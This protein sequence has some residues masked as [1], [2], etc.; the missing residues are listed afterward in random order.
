MP[1]MYPDTGDG[2]DG[3]GQDGKAV[4]VEVGVEVA[5]LELGYLCVHVVVNREHGVCH[6]IGVLRY[7]TDVVPRIGALA[8]WPFV[9]E[10]A[11]GDVFL[12]ALHEWG[13]L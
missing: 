9:G 7:G 3:I 12:Y 11:I 6:E 10:E 4:V 1:A 2:V 13:E 5:L 8:A